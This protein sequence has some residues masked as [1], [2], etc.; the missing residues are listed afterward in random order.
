MSHLRFYLPI[1]GL[2]ICS[3]SSTSTAPEESKKEVQQDLLVGRIAALYP[4]DGYMLIQRYRNIRTTE[5]TVYYSRNQ[6]GE[7]HSI[8]LNEQKQGQFY[9]ADIKSSNFTIN[10]P[11]FQRTIDVPLQDDLAQSDTETANSL[12]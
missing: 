8:A 9:V 11:V 2:I 4:D 5:N 1:L 10:D 12:D 6:H 3:C 7:I